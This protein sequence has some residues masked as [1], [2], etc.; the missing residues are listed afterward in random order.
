MPRILGE[1]SFTSMPGLAPAGPVDPGSSSIGSGLKSAGTS[2]Y[3]AGVEAERQ[4]KLERD[5]ANRLELA[6]AKSL[7]YQSKV[8]ADNHYQRD[9]DYSSIPERYDNDLGEA[10]NLAGELISDDYTRALF[11]EEIDLDRA[12]GME[13][14]NALAFSK[15]ADVELAGFYQSAQANKEAF[16]QGDEATRQAI[17]D[18]N[19]VHLEGLYGEG[20]IDRQRLVE[21]REEVANDYS[22]SLLKTM[23]PA[24]QIDYLKNDDSAKNLPIDVY[25]RALMAAEEADVLGKAL[26]SVDG[27]IEKHDGD[28]QAILAGISE[29]EDPEVRK[30]ARAEA[31][32]ILNQREVAIAEGQDAIKNKFLSGIAEGQSLSE[33]RQTNQEDWDQLNGAQKISLLSVE[34]KEPIKTD[35]SAYAKVSELL[36]KGRPLDA[37][38]F[39]FENPDKF[40]DGQ[41]RELLDRT[42]DPARA[43]GFLTDTARISNY[44]ERYS[45]SESDKA[46]LQIQYD[47][48]L[49][50][51]TLKG[52]DPDD[53]AKQGFIDQSLIEHKRGWFSD[54][55]VFEIEDPVE[56]ARANDLL[57]EIR[58]KFVGRYGTQPSKE[59][60]Q[61]LYR[62][63][64]SESG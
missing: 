38:K 8:K 54:T 22:I 47:D 57:A 29:I 25:K 6:K 14:I 55:S 19:E 37:R 28:R 20:I 56:R 48:W 35:R 23:K 31:T 41:F 50:S 52:E 7:F 39:V 26:S 27:L 13:K 58:N 32:T 59:Q 61:K 1:E 36:R 64:T 30:Q 34:K 43:E 46:D 45:L 60:L 17:I 4:S 40:S 51:Q 3:R 21:M 24:Q 10:A 2:F 11:E 53:A 9:N 63:A 62:K 15:R 12:Q 44:A 16:I 49:R 42:D 5:K 33:L 18:A